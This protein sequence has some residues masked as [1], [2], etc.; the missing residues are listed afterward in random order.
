MKT[1]DYHKPSSVDEAS[2]LLAQGD[3]MALAGGMTII[4][5]MKQRLNSPRAVVDLSAI[6]ELRVIEMHK[7][8]GLVIGAMAT[9]AE[10]AA[11][12]LVREKIPALAKLANGIG[13][14]QVRNRGTCGGSIANNDPAADYPAAL[15]ALGGDVHTNKREI[16]ADDYFQGMFTTALE[17][18]KGEVIRHLHLHVPETAAYKKFAQPASLYA[19]AGVFVAKTQ[20]GVRVAVT[21]AGSDGVFRIK[22]FE[23]AL[24]KKF[25]PESVPAASP[26]G[27][28]SD[29]HGSPE[30]RAS[31][32]T[33]LTK[34]AVSSC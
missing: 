22:E 33:T 9:H 34:R 23:D 32:I 24:T 25:S 17:E 1:F 11:H 16:K 13:D 31:L 8:K 30:Y 20:D 10:V 15:L 21:G 3:A 26:K 2:K 29:L 12:D 5:T 6:G 14:A 19:L 18:G 4:P 27:L 28:L 7:T